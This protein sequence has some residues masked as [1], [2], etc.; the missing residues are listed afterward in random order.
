MLD[1]RAESIGTFSH[2]HSTS[3]PC[4]IGGRIAHALENRG[5]RSET[6]RRSLP[7]RLSLLAGSNVLL[8]LRINGVYFRYRSGMNHHRMT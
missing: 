4:R 2:A 1:S 3:K 8:T 6:R 5:K 7:R